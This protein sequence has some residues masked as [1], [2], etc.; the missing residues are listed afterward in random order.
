MLTRR[1]HRL[2]AHPLT[3]SHLDYPYVATGRRFRLQS[4]N[5]SQV[6][7]ITYSYLKSLHVPT[8]RGSLSNP[9]HS[10]TYELVRSS[11]TSQVIA[12]TNSTF[13]LCA[14]R[15]MI[16]THMQVLSIK[17]YPFQ[18]LFN[19]NRVFWVCIALLT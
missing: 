6:T 15:L 1:Q 17:R 5:P 13:E 19:R 2:R 3:H 16:P 8:R 4:L 18:G 7:I 9:L 11:S 14:H 12:S 10:R